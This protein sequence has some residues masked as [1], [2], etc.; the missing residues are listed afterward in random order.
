MTD[1]GIGQVMDL[2]PVASGRV[3]PTALAG[4]PIALQDF[5]PIGFPFRRA[6]ILVVHAPEVVVLAVAT[7][8]ADQA[9]DVL[10]HMKH[11]PNPHWRPSSRPSSASKS[12]S[13]NGIRL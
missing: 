5:A 7:T 6:H 12:A 2:Q 3:Q 9:G 10:D 8:G 4:I 1:A 11:I 13:R